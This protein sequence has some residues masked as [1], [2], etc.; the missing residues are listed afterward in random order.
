[1]VKRE[2]S[3]RIYHEGKCTVIS[4]WG[5]LNRGRAEGEEGLENKSGIHIPPSQ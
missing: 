4:Q 2:R 5:N 3:Q 1:M